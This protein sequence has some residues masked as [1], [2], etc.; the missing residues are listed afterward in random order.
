MHT[1]T[2]IWKSI[3]ALFIGFRNQKQP[4]CLL[5]YGIL[6]NNK[7]EIIIDVHKKWDK[8]KGNCIACEKQIPKA[9]ILHYAFYMTFLKW[10]SGIKHDHVGEGGHGCKRV[11]SFCGN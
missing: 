9:S 7:N 8:S 10:L 5:Y 4:K 2:H 1:E 6:F 3:A 11:A